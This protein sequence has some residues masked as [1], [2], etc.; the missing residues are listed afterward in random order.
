MPRHWTGL[1]AVSSLILI[2]ALT[3]ARAADTNNMPL[4]PDLRSVRAK[5]KAK[6]FKAALAELQPLEGKGE[7]ADVYNLMGF[8]YR[9]S[10][11]QTRAFVYYEKALALDPNHRGALEYQGELFVETRQLDKA[12]ANLTRLGR[13]CPFGC[14]EWTDLDEAIKAAGKPR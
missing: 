4:A 14:E 3:E 2:A 12:K 10:G 11:D 13:L 9:K 6:D 1:V 5:I 7:F 8:S